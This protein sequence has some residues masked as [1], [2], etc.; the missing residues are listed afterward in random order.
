MQYGDCQQII[1]IKLI[2]NTTK[3]FLNFYKSNCYKF[4]FLK[5]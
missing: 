5:K 1:K 2:F 4:I 3:L